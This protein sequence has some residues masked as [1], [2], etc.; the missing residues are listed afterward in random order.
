MEPDVTQELSHAAAGKTPLPAGVAAPV[1]KVDDVTLASLLG[2]RICHDLVSPVGA[3]N[4]GVEIID[5][6][7]DPEFRDH[8]MRVIS[9]GA[10]Q[11][12]SR[13]AFYRVA[14][15]AGSGLADS[16]HLD[17][18]RELVTS[19]FDGS[20]LTVEWEPD[21]ETLDRNMVKLFLNLILIGAEALP[22]GGLLRIGVMRKAAVNLIVIAEGPS[23]KFGDRVRT[24]LRHGGLDEDEAPLQPKEAPIVLT[25]RLA[26][27]LGA[28]LSFGEE[29]GRVVL[30]ATL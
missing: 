1:A 13:L 15:G 8:A 11:A 6:G 30:A 7:A 20:R 22:R 21:E 14:F 2:S 3:L 5:G 19:F 24:L 16:A 4:N 25:N 23:T 17:E 27:Q 26:E 9:Q 10:R 29:D 12:K 28:E 18:V